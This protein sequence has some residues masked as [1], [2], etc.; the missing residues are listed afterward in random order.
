MRRKAEFGILGVAALAAISIVLVRGSMVVR[1]KD[2]ATQ[3]P[4]TLGELDELGK[5]LQTASS[6]ES[7]NAVVTPAPDK[8]AEA[9]TVA[10]PSALART[11]SRELLAARFEDQRPGMRRRIEFRVKAFRAIGTVMWIG[12]KR[13]AAGWAWELGPEMMS[14]GEWDEA[15]RCFWEALDA[16][17]APA[18]HRFA[19]ARLAWLEEDAKKAVRFLD[20]SC[21]GDPSGL[22]LPNAIDLCRATESDALAEH[23]LAR[24]RVAN[25]RSARYYDEEDGKASGERDDSE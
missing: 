1:D 18:M 12:S 7:A 17:L 15:R 9:A 13:V 16:P 2:L 22:W 20:L 6:L 23:Y 21:Q 24:L 8:P 11:A 14:L 19:C 10:M 3:Q 25:P 5:R 4:P